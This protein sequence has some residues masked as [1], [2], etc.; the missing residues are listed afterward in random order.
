[1]VAALN[2]VCGELGMSQY[3]D[4]GLIRRDGECQHRECQHRERLE[5]VLLACHLYIPFVRF[6]VSRVKA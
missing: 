6:A 5:G 4:E 1:M 2:Q 3:K